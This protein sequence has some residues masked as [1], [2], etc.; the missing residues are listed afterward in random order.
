MSLS[1]QVLELIRTGDRHGR[2]MGTASLRA[3]LPRTHPDAL[4]SIVGALIKAGKVYNNAGLLHVTLE[5]PPAPPKPELPPPR[6]RGRP[7]KNPEPER[8]LRLH[9]TLDVRRV[10]GGEYVS[11]ELTP[12]AMD[13]V[14]AWWTRHRALAAI[15]N[16]SKGEG[17]GKP[18]GT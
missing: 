11:L 12:D 17:D 18:N 7:R 15:N 1:E 6:K 10:R 5:V 14:V 3:A 8:G 2:S 16:A 4:D 13:V 9:A